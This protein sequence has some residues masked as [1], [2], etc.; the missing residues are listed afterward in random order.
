MMQCMNNDFSNEF[1]KLGRV[2]GTLRKQAGLYQEELAFRASIDRT[3]ISQIERG[4]GNPSLLIVLKIAKA[5]N[6][7]I[8][9]LFLQ[10]NTSV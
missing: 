8:S 7:N 3:Y 10:F 4:V 2:I 1:K 5:I 9:T 6:V